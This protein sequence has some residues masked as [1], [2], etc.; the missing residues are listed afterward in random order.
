MPQAWEGE[1]LLI[2]TLR[3]RPSPVSGLCPEPPSPA[4]REREGAVA[5][6]T[7]R[8]RASPAYIARR[9]ARRFW[10]AEAAGAAGFAAAMMGWFGTGSDQFHSSSP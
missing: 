7:G 3:I 8:A 5:T 4:M 1:G 10:K 9:R 2:E 6:A